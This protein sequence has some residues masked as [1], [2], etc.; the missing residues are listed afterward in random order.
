M[1]PIGY[2]SITEGTSLHIETLIDAAANTRLAVMF[3]RKGVTR[4][5][6]PARLVEPYSFTDG[7][8]DIMVRCY[9][10]QQDDD[11]SLSGWRFF[12]AHKID[13]VEPTTIQFKPRRR[14]SLPTGEVTAQY[15]PSPHWS[16]EGRRLYRDLVGDAIADGSISPGERFDISAVKAKCKLKEEDI[17]FVHA[18]VYHRC[19]GAVLDDG[20][21]ADHEL[22]EIRFLH[23]AMRMLGWAV[24]D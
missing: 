18:S 5:A 24:G 1:T 16:D 22:E 8:Q 12:M 11:A 10:L 17:R 20:F 14:I 21:I 6:I 3:Y 2:P 15:E 9:Q 4:A 19:L 23:Q 13:R 7:K